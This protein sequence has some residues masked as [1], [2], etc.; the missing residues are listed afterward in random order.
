MPFLL[1]HQLEPT[2]SEARPWR[3]SCI[4]SEFHHVF[5]SSGHQCP[6]GISWPSFFFFTLSLAPSSGF[7]RSLPLP[8]LICLFS[9]LVF[10]CL[11]LFVRNL[12]NV[13][14]TQKSTKTGAVDNL[15][16]YLMIA[17]TIIPLQE[18][19][20]EHQHNIYLR[21]TRSRLAFL[22]TN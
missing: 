6:Y 3:D 18:Y 20:L 14:N 8:S 17:Q 22:I 15:I 5:W 7:Q 16:L 12:V 2:T 13:T 9:S 21:T 10:R 1:E 19:D 11:G 4:H